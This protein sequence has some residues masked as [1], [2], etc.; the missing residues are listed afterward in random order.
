[1]SEQ[2]EKIVI[3]VELRGN[4]AK[5]KIDEVGKSA[6]KTGKKIKT[7]K[8]ETQGFGAA[9]GQLGAGASGAF[10]QMVR[11]LK[12]VRLALASTGI[13]LIVIA[14]GALV[15]G[16]SRFQGVVD[17]VSQ[18]TAGAGV[19]FSKLGD[20]IG[21]VG[22]FIVSAFEKPTEF[23]AGFNDTINETFGW[24]ASLGKLIKEG[25]VLTLLGLRKT[26]LKVRI[27]FNEFFG[28]DEEANELKGR[29][30]EVQEEIEKTKESIEDSARAV[31]APLIEM[32]AGVSN[33]VTELKEAAIAAAE[34]EKAS[35]KLE[36]VQI[37]QIETQAIRNKQIAEARLVA[38]DESK[39][40]AERTRALER[41]LELEN[42]TLQEKLAN[43]KENA[44]IISEQNALA[45]SS[46]DDLRKEAEAKAEVARL[47]EQS[48]RQQKRIFT[49][50]QT[51]QKQAAEAAKKRAEEE[52]LQRLKDSIESVGAARIQA[53]T[54]QQDITLPALQTGSKAHEQISEQIERAAKAEFNLSEE[55]L[56]SAQFFAQGLQDIS[57]VI[58]KDSKA[59]FE[60]N[61]AL[62]IATTTISTFTSAQEAYRSQLALATPDAP[63]RGALAAGVAVAQGLARVAA[64]RKTTFEGGG[65][66]SSGA[67]RSA[68]GGGSSPSQGF[69]V[70]STPT[71]ADTP[72]PEPVQAYV[73]GQQ[74]TNQQALDSE[75][76]LRSTL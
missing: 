35:Q 9:L 51:L 68:G 53:A 42:A 25:F 70:P 29:L 47:E 16:M 32:A 18:L 49:E 76:K 37:S 28:D 45:E 64:I 73:I 40:F 67:P 44:R 26:I 55:R 75:L 8:Q 33:L 48:L 10:G 11:G 1:M 61:K 24:F 31:A 56:K 65:S 21:T 36:D 5:K 23:I 17:K 15:A 14:V 62:Q 20:A 46:R 38:E 27:A 13:G 6:D 41:A 30:E 74:I 63:I 54:I 39:S 4:D 34:L 2:H 72:Q 71:A 59:G 12:A 57:G 7:S 69:L 22:K 19:V 3:D 52:E 60:V 43:A 50:L 66:G 58:A